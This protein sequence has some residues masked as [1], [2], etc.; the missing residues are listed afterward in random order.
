MEHGAWSVEHGA[1]SME[2]GAPPWSTPPWLS[3]ILEHPPRIP[4]PPLDPLRIE[5]S[6]YQPIDSL[7]RLDFE[8]VIY[9][10]IDT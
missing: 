7:C 6:I 9:I 8:Y 4:R 1:W 3:N 10:S 5:S 2:H